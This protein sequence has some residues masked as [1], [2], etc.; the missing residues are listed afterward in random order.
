MLTVLTIILEEFIVKR[1]IIDTIAAYETIIIHRHVRPDPDAYGSQLGL[2]ELILANYPEKKV[3]AVGDHDASLTFMAQPDQVA[4]AVYEHALVIVTDTANT[5]RVDDQRYTKGKMM[6]KID[7]HPNDDAYGDL[8][9]VD[10]T[11]SSCSE[12]IYELYEEGK[13]VANWQL[14]DTAARLLFAGIVGD[15]G[16]FQFPST[17][18]KTFKVAADLITYD[19]DR[20]QIFDGMYEMEQKLLNL[21]GYIY[22]NF[23]MDEY[24]AAHV[25]LT[26]EL[27]AEHD[28]VPSEA[29]LLVGC[30]G[31]VK[32]ICS[33][34]V[35]IEEEDQ[36][37]VRLRSKGPIINTLAKEFNGGGHPLASGATA[38]SWKEADDV[39]I[40][41]QE[42]CK[43]YH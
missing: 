3:F 43:A 15:T 19:F 35:F 41:L 38:Y 12:M 9:W 18:A 13:E 28:I 21:Q 4:D 33:W 39:I 5:E 29:S 7:H 22:Q 17:T 36:I 34:V 40:R 27:L 16:R 14:S 2:K 30:L 23:K 24:G 37:R 11:A 26:K 32:G 1:Q 10:T 20:N 8:L 31:S 42:I 6:I 25:K